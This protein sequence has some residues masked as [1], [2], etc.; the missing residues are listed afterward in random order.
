MIKIRYVDPNK[1]SPGLHAAVECHGRS[2]TVYLLCGLRPQQRQ[3]A[4]RR[5]RMSARMGYCPALPAPQLAFARF[6]DRIRTGLGQAGAVVRSHPAASTVPLM[7][8]SAGAIGFLL[9][10]TVSTGAH[11]GPRTPG[12]LAAAPRPARAEGAGGAEGTAA[13]ANAAP[14]PRAPVGPVPGG[15]APASNAPTGGPS[16]G[17][18]PLPGGLIP[19]PREGP[20]SELL[21]PAPR[22]S[23]GVAAFTSVPAR[24]A[25]APRLRPRRTSTGALA[26]PRRTSTAP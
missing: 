20:D 26:R 5:L 11:P 22:A 16:A 18:P 17:L 6:K 7:L 4:F 2:T 23:I 25:R 10:A 14:I 1:I 3:A 19:A 8:V 12:P 24:A 9:L 13:L 15:P 21:T